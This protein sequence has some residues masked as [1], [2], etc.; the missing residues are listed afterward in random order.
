[1]VINAEKKQSYQ[2]KFAGR[3]IWKF[4]K[5]G[6]ICDVTSTYVVQKNTRKG[7]NC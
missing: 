3:L 7:V 6:P 2:L 1:M 5:F 4:S